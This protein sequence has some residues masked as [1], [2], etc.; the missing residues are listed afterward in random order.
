MLLQCK[1]ICP[2]REVR[3]Q[4]SVIDVRTIRGIIQALVIRTEAQL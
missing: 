3:A 1:V 2:A 4:I